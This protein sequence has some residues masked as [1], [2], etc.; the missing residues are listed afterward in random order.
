[1]IGERGTVGRGRDTRCR[2]CGKVGK[3]RTIKNNGI[4]IPACSRCYQ[5]IQIKNAKI[6]RGA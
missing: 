5:T 3:V 4:A 6:K 1:M 2:S